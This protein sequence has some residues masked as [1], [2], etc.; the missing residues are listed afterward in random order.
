[1]A[2]QKGGGKKPTMQIIQEEKVSFLMHMCTNT[3][4]IGKN[5]DL[6]LLFIS[7]LF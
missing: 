3:L 1:M 7:S 5:S 6:F 2:V 4:M